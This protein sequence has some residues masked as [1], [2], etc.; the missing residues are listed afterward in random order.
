MKSKINLI[1]KLKKLFNIETEKQKL[2]NSTTTKITK[3]YNRGQNT[4]SL[5]DFWQ[6]H[7]EMITIT[8][9]S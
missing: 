6:D 2:L 7:C 9:V 8:K 3:C 5:T 4:C 1:G